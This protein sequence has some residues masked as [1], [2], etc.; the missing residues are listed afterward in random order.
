MLGCL[1]ALA[2]KMKR[3]WRLD[4]EWRQR[5]VDGG[6]IEPLQSARRP[7]GPE[8][9]A[10]LLAAFEFHAHFLARRAV[11]SELVGDQNTRRAGLLTNGLSQQPFGS[12]LGTPT[13]DQRVKNK[14][15]RPS[16][17]TIKINLRLLAL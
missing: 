15:L 16:T 1:Q 6:Q 13:P 9:S 12:A 7:V 10:R 2:G 14:C 8:F 3:G 4:R 5:A 11:R 17:V